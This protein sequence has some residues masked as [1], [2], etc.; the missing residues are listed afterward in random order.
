MSAIAHSL[1][2]IGVIT[3]LTFREAQRRKLLWVG[4]ALGIA[5]V[6]LYAV[7]YYF[8]WQDAS[9]NP[10]WSASASKLFASTFVTAGLYVVNFLVVMVTV[11]TSVGTISAEIANST[12]HAIAAK[13]LHRWE[14]ILGKW[15][16]HAIMLAIYTLLLSAGVILSVYLISGY[17]PGAIVSGLLILVVESL[18]ILSVTFLGGTLLNT[19]ANGVTVFML[20]GV[21]FV[22]GWV[23]QFGALLSSQTAKDIGIASSLLLPS[24]ALWRYATTLMQPTNV[25]GLQMTPFTVSSKPSAAFV[26][27]A[28]I[29]I[30]GLLIAAMGA[31]SRRDF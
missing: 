25:T 3:R 26:I 19:L 23:E 11:L 31:F 15:L 2:Q 16:G 10:Y 29:Y 21:A 12:I 13:P 6:V 20:Y 8:A 22:G 18:C 1:Q 28:V 27:Y 5:F 24:E 14:I 9:R 17:K 30:V 7:G 4:L